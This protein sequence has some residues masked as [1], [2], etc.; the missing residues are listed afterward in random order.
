MQQQICESVQDVVKNAVM[1]SDITIL[2][3]T[4]QTLVRVWFS[5]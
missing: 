2:S 3:Y 5:V 1:I 4:D